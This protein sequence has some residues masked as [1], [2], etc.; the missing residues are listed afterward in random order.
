LVEASG[1]DAVTGVSARWAFLLLIGL[2]VGIVV[3]AAW[4]VPWDARPVSRADRLAALAQLPPEQVARGRS[5]RAAQRPATYGSLVLGLAVV[6]ILGLTP[7]GAR[8][9]DL[10]ASPFGGHWLAAAVL[11]GLAVVLTGQLATVPLAAWRH[12]KAVE[13]GLSTQTWRAWGVDLL[14]ATAVLAVLAAVTLAAFFT[15]ARLLPQWWWLPAALG[16]AMLVVLL[17]LVVPVLVEPLFIN[18]APMPPGELHR[19]LLRLAQRDGVPVRQVLVADAS[20]RSRA[21]NA[22]V[23]GLGPTRRLVVFDTLLKEAPPEQVEAVVAHELAHAKHRDVVTGT[24]L[25]A[26][27][28]AA[29]VT[30]LFLLGRWDVLLAAGGVGAVTE[31]QAVALLVAVVA[32]AA[33]LTGPAQALVSRRLEARADA[34]GLALSG[35]PDAVTALHAR[36]AEVNLADPDPPRWE[37]LLFA[38]HPTTAERMAAAQVRVRGES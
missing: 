2:I 26:L 21:V 38:S 20:R 6:L 24:L 32:V 29:A 4:L 9:V 1:I 18:F 3:A 12:A 36:M 19:S 8:L 22:Y 23:S 30:G 16:A 15:V 5:Y 11:G 13:H 25:S 34:H 28:A 35:D 31:P 27:G 14:K 37:Q 10:V 17:S 7:A 33:V